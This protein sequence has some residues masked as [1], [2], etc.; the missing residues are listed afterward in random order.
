M[1]ENP[2][3]WRIYST[4]WSSN[5]KEL[6]YLIRKNETDAMNIAN[7]KESQGDSSCAEIMLFHPNQDTQA[8]REHKV[9]TLL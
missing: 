8:E 4:K 5:S 7:T 1:Q 2:S 9:L 3:L 6:S